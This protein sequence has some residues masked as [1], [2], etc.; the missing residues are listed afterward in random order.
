MSSMPNQAKQHFTGVTEKNWI[1]ITEQTRLDQRLCRRSLQESRTILAY[2]GMERST[3]AISSLRSYA[4]NQLKQNQTGTVEVRW[5]R[6]VVFSQYYGC[7]WFTLSPKPNTMFCLFSGTSNNT[8]K[9]QRFHS[10]YTQQQQCQPPQTPEK[11]QDQTSISSQ[12]SNKPPKFFG[13]GLDWTLILQAT[14]LQM[15]VRDLHMR[16]WDEMYLITR[17][18]S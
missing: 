11:Q 7:I 8:I 18:I 6:E 4:G 5:T 1:T 14:L 10:D 13:A 16:Y 15:K 2:F 9:T 3:L 12:S 17:L